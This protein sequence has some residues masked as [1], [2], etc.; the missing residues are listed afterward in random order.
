MTMPLDCYDIDFDLRDSPIR[1]LAMT[2]T[3]QEVM[4]SCQRQ[5]DRDILGYTTASGSILRL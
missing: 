4:A 3:A 1:S 2:Q 5:K